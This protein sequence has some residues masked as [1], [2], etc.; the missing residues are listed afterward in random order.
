MQA[1]AALAH[2]ES[3]KDADVLLVAF[4]QDGSLNRRF[5]LLPGF[6]ARGIFGI[7]A[8]DPSSRTFLDWTEFAA[9]HHSGRVR[10]VRSPAPQP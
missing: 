4:F 9:A 5:L 3:L 1:S 10:L 7:E 8:Y 6:D 2:A